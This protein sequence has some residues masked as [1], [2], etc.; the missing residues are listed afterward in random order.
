MKLAPSYKNAG[1][2][3]ARYTPTA[4]SRT[5]QMKSYSASRTK[6]MAFMDLVVTSEIFPGKVVL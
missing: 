1:P 2:S 3:N 4:K 5:P 6:K